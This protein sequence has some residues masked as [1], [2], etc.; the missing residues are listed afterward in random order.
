[1]KRDSRPLKPV[2]RPS[3]LFRRKLD[4]YALAAGAAAAC[5]LVCAPAA[6]EVIFTRANVV[7]GPNNLH[8][9][10]LDLNNDGLT[11]F[12]I[13]SRLTATTSG[14]DQKLLITD[15]IP[16]LKGVEVNGAVGDAGE[17]GNAAA[18]YSGALI[19]QG[20]HFWGFLL[21]S[22]RV[23]PGGSSFTRGDWINVT[24]RYLGLKFEINREIHYGWARLTVVEKEQNLQ[25]TL[26]GYAYETVANRPIITGPTETASDAQSST[27]PQPASL[28]LLAAGTTGLSARRREQAAPTP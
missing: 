25:A 13:E 20:R 3:E 26:T 23:A 11:D 8:I 15:P 10:Q 17:A 19:G 27:S 28:G 4:H 16:T 2:R 1:M 22:V 18:L 14:G 5:A 24:N 9:Y 21:G 12:V 7:L 6:A